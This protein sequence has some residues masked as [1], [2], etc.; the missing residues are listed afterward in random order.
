MLREM[1]KPGFLPHVRAMGGALETMLTRIT[2]EFSHVFSGIRGV[3]LMRGLVVARQERKYP[4]AQAL[5]EAGLLT[6]P[7]VSDVLRILPP[8]IIEPYHI[9][10]AYTLLAQ[11]AAKEAV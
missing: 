11:V 3:G 8:L 10:Q 2:Q 6:A 9:E 1:Q 4:L 7:A 5:R